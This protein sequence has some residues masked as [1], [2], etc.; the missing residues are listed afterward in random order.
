MVDVKNIVVV[1][2]GLMGNGIAQVSLMAGYNV[3]LVDVKDEFLDKA[4]ANIE[5]GL[6]K[7]ESKGQLGEGVTAD[8]LMAKLN[9][10]SSNTNIYHIYK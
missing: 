7:S 10:T 5:K 4:F 1:G 3:T 6:K 9:R 8:A 2:S